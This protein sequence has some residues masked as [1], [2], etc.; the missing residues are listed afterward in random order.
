MRGAP[1]VG[2]SAT[3]WKITLR[4]SLFIGVRPPLGL[5]LEIHF[6][7]NRKPARCQCVSYESPGIGV[8]RLNDLQFLMQCFHDIYCGEIATLRIGHTSQCR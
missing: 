4:I 3:I 8:Y 6:Q 2:F 5:A 1:H 7:Y